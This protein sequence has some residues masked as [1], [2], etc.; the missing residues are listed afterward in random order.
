MKILSQNLITFITAFF[1]SGCNYLL[2]GQEYSITAHE[3]VQIRPWAGEDEVL[4]NYDIIITNLHPIHC[5]GD[6]T[7]NFN[8]CWE[9]ILGHVILFLTNYL[10]LTTHPI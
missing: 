3:V 5:R 7:S 8:E 2:Q 10:K 6:P 4:P 1:L 9:L